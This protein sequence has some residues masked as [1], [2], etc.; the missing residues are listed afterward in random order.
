MTGGSGRA[1]LD[2]SEPRLEAAPPGMDEAALNAA[3]AATASLAEVS[4]C[5]TCSAC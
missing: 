5:F 1:S 3:A 4:A 2:A